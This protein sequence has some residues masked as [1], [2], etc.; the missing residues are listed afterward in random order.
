M[1][2]RA[3]GYFRTHLAGIDWDTFAIEIARL[4]LTLADVPN[5]DGWRVRATDMFLP[6]A[7][8]DALQECSVVLSNPPFEDFNPKARASYEGKGVQLQTNNR[9]AELVLRILACVRPGTVFGLVVPQSFLTRNDTARVRRSLLEQSEL[10]EVCLLP[11][12]VFEYASH[13]SALIIGRKVK[14]AAGN[15]VLYRRVRESGMARFRSRYAASFEQVVRQTRFLEAEL[16]EMRVPELG[17]VW[18]QCSVL[19]RFDTMAEVGK[20]L[21]FIAQETLSERNLLAYSS[22][23]D[24]IPDAARGFRT[25]EG[26]PQIHGLP[27]GEYFNTDRSVIRRMNSAASGVP[28]VLLN[29]NKVSRGP[30]CLKAFLDRRGHLATNNFLLVRP[31]KPSW[32]LEFL[33]ALCVSPIANA[34]VYSRSDK[35]HVTADILQALPVPTASEEEVASVVVAARHY[36]AAARALDE[37]NHRA[38]QRYP[39]H[40]LFAL[41]RLLLDLDAQVLRLYDLPPRIECDALRLFDGQQRSGVPCPFERYYAEDYLPCFSLT[42]F[43][44]EDYAGSTAGALRE[45]F[46][47]VTDE[48]LLKALRLAASDSCE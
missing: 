34:F 6:R 44:S 48:K 45:S 18:D 19:P 35:R 15:S 10:A 26:D 36:R 2:G 28:Q 33:W 12:T 31:R 40:G 29:A 3:S 20:G 47:P 5:P 24:R 14:H 13:E 43:L 37:A 38:P 17:A 21:E 11:D 25:L 27:H 22:Q 9:A 8:D 39:K 23:R 16:C 30:W 41:Q 1:P 46:H 7:M 4:S 32:P 42:D